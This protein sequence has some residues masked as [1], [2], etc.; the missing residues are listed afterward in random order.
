MEGNRVPVYLEY[1]DEA[2]L[3]SAYVPDVPGCGEGSTQAEA[4]ADL[5]ESLRAYIEACGLDKVLSL[6]RP[7]AQ[8]LEVDLAE[9]TRG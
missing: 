8:V 5:K 1:D 6:I 4:I 7:P 9:L 2:K 3:F